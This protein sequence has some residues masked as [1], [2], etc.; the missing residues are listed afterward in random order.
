MAALITST[1]C[2]GLL[3]DIQYADADDG[4][5]FDGATA[6]H[7]RNSLA[8]CQEASKFFRATSSSGAPLFCVQLGDVL[9]AKAKQA[10]QQKECLE[11]VLAIT[12]GKTPG[13]DWHFLV[14]NHD[15]YCFSR[16]EI[17]DGGFIPEPYRSAGCSPTRL[18]Y[19][20]CPRPGFRVVILD[21]YE[22]STLG[23]ISDA[24]GSLAK[25]LLDEKNPNVA[26]GGGGSWFTGIPE[27][28]QKF[29]PFN[30]GFSDEQLQWLSHTLTSAGA[31]DEKCF[32]F[33]HC[34]VHPLATY[35]MGL[36]WNNEDVLRII[37]SVP[38]GCVAAFISG[39]NHE[40]AYFHDQT[41][42][43]HHLTPVSPL[44]VAVGDSA[45]GL[46][47]VDDDG[48]SLEWVGAQTPPRNK[49]MWPA[50][51]HRLSFV[52]TEPSA[53]SSRL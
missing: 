18:F 14:G 6:R 35:P 12:S 20:F 22:I 11:R 10:G 38:R 49:Y 26:K 41:T 28:N 33:S 16:Q 42:G 44:E 40:G 43:T 34:P 3:S 21:P 2:F 7:Y 29:V 24:L 36:S 32:I 19:S 52:S 37:E 23:P 13:I 51:P 17:F 46:V 39:H 1:W 4:A 47:H 53:P 15:L 30:G 5:T 27:H 8:I 48:F 31:S 45:F 25:Q 50:Q 9:D